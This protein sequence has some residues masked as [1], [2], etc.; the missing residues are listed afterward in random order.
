[1]V[2][3]LS[4]EAAELLEDARA[5]T[6]GRITIESKDSDAEDLGLLFARRFGELSLDEIRQITNILNRT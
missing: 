1:M 2:Y 3:N 6:L 5:K 4:E